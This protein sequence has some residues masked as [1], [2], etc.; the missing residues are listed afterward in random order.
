MRRRDPVHCHC[1]PPGYTRVDNGQVTLLEVNLPADKFKCQHCFLEI[2]GICR[3]QR[4]NDIAQQQTF[5][6]IKWIDFI[7]YFGLD[8]MRFPIG[9]VRQIQPVLSGLNR[10]ISGVVLDS[11]PRHPVL[12]AHPDTLHWS[13]PRP[14]ARL[15]K[16]DGCIDFETEDSLLWSAGPSAAANKRCPESNTR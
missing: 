7:E 16:A 15:K 4:A 12:A 2:G 10:S 14:D 1:R 11:S 8:F 5:F 6:D 13:V 3:I 9:Q